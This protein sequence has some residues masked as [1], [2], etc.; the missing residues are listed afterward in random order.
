MMMN[1]G[2]REGREGA[3]SIRDSSLPGISPLQINMNAR[4]HMHTWR[5]ANNGGV[6]Q[7]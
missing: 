1:R 4:A 5:S 2:R 6:S 3:A 7:G